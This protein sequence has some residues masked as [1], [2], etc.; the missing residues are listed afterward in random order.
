MRPLIVA[1]I[2]VGCVGLFVAGMFL[3]RS[4]FQR[5]ARDLSHYRANYLSKSGWI[6]SH[7]SYNFRSF[8]GGINWWAVE[9]DAKGGLNIL[10]PADEIHPGL[11]SELEGWDNLRRYVEEHGSMTLTGPNAQRELE[12][13]TSVGITVTTK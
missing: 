11:L 12:I 3:Q 7:G 13:L 9:V 10:G 4:M 8:N 1:L 2:I 6:S 5:D